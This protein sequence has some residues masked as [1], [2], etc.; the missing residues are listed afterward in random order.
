MV[1]TRDDKGHEICRVHGYIRIR[2]IKT[3]RQGERKESEGEWKRI[4][5]K[6]RD[7]EAK[8]TSLLPSIRVPRRGVRP[9]C[10][11]FRG[12]CGSLLFLVKIISETPGARCEIYA[13]PG[14]PR[15]LI[16]TQILRIDALNTVDVPCV[17]NDIV[18]PRSLLGVR[19]G[20]DGQDVPRVTFC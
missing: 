2:E 11:F 12:D 14:A 7:G 17:I 10:S 3:E 16:H 18:S 9:G 13:R 15:G 6:K 20:G 19:V 1:R 4:G 8:D 5:G